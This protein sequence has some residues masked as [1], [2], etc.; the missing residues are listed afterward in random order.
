MSE[1]EELL[2]GGNINKV[3]RVGGTVRREAKPNLY[4]YDLL[5]HLEMRGFS[6]SPRYLGQDDKGREV[7]SYLEGDV[8]GNS[9]PDIEPYM[10]SDEAFIALAKLLRS[11]HDATVGFITSN[12]SIHNYP[13]AALHEVVCHNDAALYNVVFKDKQPAGMIDFDMAGPGPRLWDIVYTL[14]TSVPLA[15]FSPDEPNREVVD[16]HRESHASE[17]KR[18]IEL[19]CNAYG[20][21]VPL[22]LKDWVISRIKFMCTTLSE[23]ARSGDPAFV[24][25][26]E[27]GHLAHYEKEI[28]FLEKHFEDWG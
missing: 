6:Y 4:V 17:R 3:V 18:R 2:D 27:E 26:V 16:Y 21:E 23:G 28:K 8:P 14:Y 19:F 7:L 22:D 10:W 13:N 25:L 5:Q 20:M 9:Y 12:E 1:H 24:K 15:S 11:Y